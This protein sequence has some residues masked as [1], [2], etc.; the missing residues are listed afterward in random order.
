M[1]SFT[2]QTGRITEK[3]AAYCVAIKANGRWNHKFFKSYAGAQNEVKFWRSA[4]E[5][6]RAYYGIEEGPRLIKPNA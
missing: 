4:S 5:N 3:A 1:A 2:L 6:T